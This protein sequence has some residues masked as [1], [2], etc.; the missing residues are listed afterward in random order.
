M[1]DAAAVTVLRPDLQIAPI[2][3]EAARLEPYSDGRPWDS[4]LVVRE[5]HHH[6]GNLLE[7]VY[8]IGRRLLWAKEVLGHG[9]FEAW[10]EGSLPFSER[11]IQNYMRVATLF[12]ERP[13]LRQPLAAV[14]LRKVLL[15]TSLPDEVKDDMAATSLLAETPV[16]SIADKP[17]VELKKE[18]EKLRLSEAKAHEKAAAAEKTADQ[19][20]IQLAD[21]TGT[22]WSRDHEQLLGWL[23][24]WRRSY[25]Q[26]M[27]VAGVG[28]DNLARRIHE[29]PPVVQARII[30][31][32]EYMLTRTT[33]EN[34]RFRELAG[35]EVYGAAFTETLN[36]PRPCADVYPIPEGRVLPFFGD[37]E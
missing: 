23:E 34:L 19:L 17:Y 7:S 4:G 12:I 31:L 36:R 29:L 27:A 32:S 8:E 35:Q 22:A 9:H 3:A 6:T 5:I 25:D 24:D 18:V 30:G 33:Y 10:W 13:A 14:G 16:A 28:L 2:D 15:L 37:A 20:K 21:A 1:P 26:A 11:T